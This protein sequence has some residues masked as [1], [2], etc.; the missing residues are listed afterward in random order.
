MLTVS[1]NEQQTEERPVLPSNYHPVAGTAC[2]RLGQTTG[3]KQKTA[4]FPVPERQEYDESK[5]K[6]KERKL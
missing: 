5:A 4:I 2:A 1:R 3:P 6:F